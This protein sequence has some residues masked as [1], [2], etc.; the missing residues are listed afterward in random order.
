[1]LAKDGLATK[2][3]QSGDEI[4]I[5]PFQ[6][7]V[8]GGDHAKLPVA[9]PPNLGFLVNDVVFNPGDSFAHDIEYVDVL[10]LPVAGP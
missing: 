7:D 5:G 1:M 2:A 6:V 3:I 10:L 8:L 9:V 4:T